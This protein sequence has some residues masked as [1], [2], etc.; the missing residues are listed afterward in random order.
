MHRPAVSGDAG[1]FKV[2]ARYLL[3]LL[4]ENDDVLFRE[5]FN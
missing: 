1:A 4:N 2:F 5:I 3:V